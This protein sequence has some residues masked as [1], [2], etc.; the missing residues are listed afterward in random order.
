MY[1][2]VWMMI[3]S[4]QKMEYYHIGTYNSERE[5]VAELGKAKPL[6]TNKNQTLAC[7]DLN[8]GPND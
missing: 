4:T 7:L 8:K 6:V 1:A 3:I 5:C 2:L